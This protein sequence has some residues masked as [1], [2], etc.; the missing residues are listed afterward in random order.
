MPIRLPLDRLLVPVR[1]LGARVNASKLARYPSA[2]LLL[3][4]KPSDDD[5]KA[6]PHTALLPL[7]YA[8]EG[9]ARLTGHRTR[10]TVEAVRMSRKHMYF[11]SDKAVRELGYSWRPVTLAFEDAIAWLREQGLLR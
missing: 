8:A 3:P 5:W 10:V 4:L 1:Q 2:L 7:A 6:L 11:S 9:L